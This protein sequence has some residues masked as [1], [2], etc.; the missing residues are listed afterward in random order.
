MAVEFRFINSYIPVAK[1]VQYAEFH[2]EYHF[3]FKGT[4]FQPPRFS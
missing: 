2:D 1:A 4:L 3:D